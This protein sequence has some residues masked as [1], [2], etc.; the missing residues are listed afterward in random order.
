M[1]VL[2]GYVFRMY[3]N[4]EQKILI[5]KTF[6]CNRFIYNHFLNEKINDYKQTGKSKTAFTQI[7]ELPKL[8]EE[9]PWLKEIDGCSLR[10]TL[11]NLEDAY[12]RFFKSSGYPKY[13]KKG[14]HER[15]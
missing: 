4:E 15:Y 6:G 2:T 12:K 5:E 10:N 14:S 9:Y 3:P 1:Q 7:K 11:F 8:Q 13:R